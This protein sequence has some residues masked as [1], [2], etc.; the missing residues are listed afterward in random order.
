[1]PTEVCHKIGFGR[2]HRESNRVSVSLTDLT[3][4]VKLPKKIAMNVIEKETIMLFIVSNQSN[5]ILLLI[6]GQLPI[7]QLDLVLYYRL[8]ID[9]VY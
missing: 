1:M 3:E 2:I 9:C 4:S 5:F 6:I 7:S 8:I